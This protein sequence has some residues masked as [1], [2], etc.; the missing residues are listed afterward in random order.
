MA[1]PNR[2]AVPPI[3]TWADITDQKVGRS[4]I[5]N[6]PIASATI[7]EAD[8]LLVPLVAGEVD[9]EEW[10]DSGLDVGE[11]KVQPVQPAQRSR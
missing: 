2:L 9:R 11:K 4:A 10:S 3:R 1:G 8:A 5:S 7:R 6:A